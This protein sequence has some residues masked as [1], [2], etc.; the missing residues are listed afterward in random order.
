[1]QKW[2]IL[3]VLSAVVYWERAEPESKVLFLPVCLCTDHHQRYGGGQIWT[4]TGRTKSRIQATEM[5]FFH[6]E[7]RLKLSGGWNSQLM[8]F[9]QWIRIYL[10]LPLGGDPREDPELTGESTYSICIGFTLGSL[11]KSWRVFSSAS[12]SVCLDGWM[13]LH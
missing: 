8:W 3:W 2:S 4:M 12:K 13:S 7:A 6:R 11:I 1:M 9:K 5:S 10:G